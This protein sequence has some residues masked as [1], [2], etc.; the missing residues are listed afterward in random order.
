MKRSLRGLVP[1]ACTV[2]V[3]SL[4]CTKAE[5]RDWV[6]SERLLARIDFASWV[7]ESFAVSR[8]NRR[9]AY[10]AVTD[11]QWYVVLDGK[12]RRRYDAIGPSL[13]FS[14]DGERLAYVARGDGMWFVV[15]GEKG[16]KPYAGI[17]TP[18][19]FSPDSRRV[20]YAAEVGNRWAVVIDGKEGRPYEGIGCAPVFGPKS[21]RVAYVAVDGDAVQVR[22]A[23][24][25]QDRCG[26]HDDGHA[27]HR[28]DAVRVEEADDERR[29]VVGAGLGVWRAAAETTF[30]VS[31]GRQGRARCY[32]R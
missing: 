5:D 21:R 2:L 10:V 25:H 19:V 1:V 30:F 11:N 6:V 22:L 15:V 12:E 26:Q 3:A 8:D 20:A 13:T 9:A 24:G 23:V 29:R 32:L 7:K 28:V 27:A 16:G 14:P 31:R 17:G 18:P 4:G